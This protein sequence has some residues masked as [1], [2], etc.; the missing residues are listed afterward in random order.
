MEG[1]ACYGDEVA[2]QPMRI[3]NGWMKIPKGPGFGVEPD[4]EKIERYRARY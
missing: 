3:V 2:C 4:L 1:P